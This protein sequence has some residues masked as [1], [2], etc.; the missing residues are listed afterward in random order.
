MQSLDSNN[1]FSLSLEHVNSKPIL[2]SF[3][4]LFE[5]GIESDFELKFEIKG[6]IRKMK[7]HRFVLYDEWPFFSSIL[8]KGDIHILSMPEITFRKIVKYFY[9]GT[10]TFREIGFYD[11]AWILHVSEF[12]LLHDKHDLLDYCK[13]L[14][15]KGI[16]KKNYKEAL[17]FG[18]DMDDENIVKSAK[19]VIS[20]EEPD[21]IL[22]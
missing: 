8:M 7:A 13:N 5:T 2:G 4:Q 16:T 10:K 22:S 20:A 9:V 3:E 17:Q 6:E 11:A 14:I 1:L 21:C 15:E 18:I 19:A 12:Y